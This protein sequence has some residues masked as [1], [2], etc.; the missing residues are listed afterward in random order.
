MR[1]TEREFEA[2]ASGEPSATLPKSIPAPEQG[3]AEVR[4][5]SERHFPRV[6][7]EFRGYNDRFER[8]CS[9]SR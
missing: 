5:P 7:L 9:V 2:V 6:L 1:E 8:E 3:R 4:L